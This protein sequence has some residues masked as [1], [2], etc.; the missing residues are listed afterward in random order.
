MSG[1]RTLR[2]IVAATDFSA[3]SG[4]AAKR[5][6]MLASQHGIPVELLHVVSASGLEAIRESVRDPPDLAQRLIDDAK[7]ALDRQAADIAAATGTQ[8]STR[9]AVSEVIREI[10]AAGDP[11]TLLVI[12][13]HGSNPLGDLLLGTTADRVARDVEGPVLVVRGEPAQ[14]YG[15]VL[16]GMDL[17]PGCGSLLADVSGLAPQARMTAVHAYELPFESTLHRAGARQ[18]EIDRLRGSALARAI[19]DIRRLSA[20]ATG[21]P[22]RV[23]AL[24]DR[25]D[26]ARLIVEK[27]RAIGADLLA[28]ARRRRSAL[29]AILIGS[30]ARRVVA[31]ADR[32]VLVLRAA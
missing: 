16:A 31:E 25:G 30:V 29:E 22:D 18:S 26:A 3:N 17:L 13:A 11:G 4:F 28:V 21:D 32:D 12:G 27:G 1:E 2:R 19:E 20:E 6:A 24:V 8:V 23:A 9:L 14:P 5:A 15:N 10:R 7:G